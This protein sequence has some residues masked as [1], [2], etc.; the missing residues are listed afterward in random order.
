MYDA[1]TRIFTRLGL[2]FRAVAADT[3][4]IGGSASHEFQVLAD[5]G[6]DAIAF[7]TRLR[8]R[9]QR[10]ARRSGR[11]RRARAAPAMR[12]ARSRHADAEAPARTSPRCWASARAHGEVG[13]RD[14]RRRLRADALV[15]GDHMRQRDQAGEAAGLW[16]FRFATEAE[17]VAH[18]GAAR[19]PRPR[20]RAS[21]PA[22]HRRPQ[23]RGD[24]DFVVGANE[25]GFHLAGVNWGRDLPEPD[26]SP[27]SAT[28]SPAIPRPTARARSRSRAASRSAT[29]SSSARKYAEA[30]G[31]PCSTRRA[32]PVPME[33]G[34]YGIGVTR[35]VA[36]AIEQNHDDNGIIWPDPMA[37]WQVAVCMINPKNDAERGRRRRG[38]VREAAPPASRRC[39]TT[40]ACAR[41]RC[42]RHRADRHPAPRRGVRARPGR[43]AEYRARTE[44]EN[45]QLRVSRDGRQSRHGAFGHDHSHGHARGHASAAAQATPPGHHGHAHATGH[46]RA[47]A[48][49][50]TL[51]LAFVATEA[52]YGAH[53]CA[54]Q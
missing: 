28:S 23:R 5:S 43:R 48:V 40:A 3:G 32:R 9:R 30:M 25:D 50:I 20:G 31:A 4:A 33:M 1:Y 22:R 27:T 47:F 11:A 35:I 14:G 51:N 34:C 45:R 37:P 16:P 6:E 54:I 19:L 7:S 13:R 17:I 12:C 39:S 36:A 26:W 52:T 46:G 38:A 41:A 2:K 29:C 15:R 49:G 24:G 44:S 53:S 21:R 42:S 18:L 10:R 8:L